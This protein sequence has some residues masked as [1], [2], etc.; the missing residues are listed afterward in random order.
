MPLNTTHFTRNHK[1]MQCRLL[2]PYESEEDGE[3]SLLSVRSV[4]SPL[5]PQKNDV[6]AV[7]QQTNVSPDQHDRGKPPTAGAGTV[8][9]IWA[10]LECAV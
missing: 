5:Q 6:Q 8:V 4:S 10:L 3:L 1:W 7:T 9:L 2:C